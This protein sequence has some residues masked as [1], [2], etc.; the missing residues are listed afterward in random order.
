MVQ[1]SILSESDLGHV[2]FIEVLKDMQVPTSWGRQC[3]S[4]TYHP[5]PQLRQFF[6]DNSVPWLVDRIESIGFLEACNV[7][8]GEIGVNVDVLLKWIGQMSRQN[9]SAG[10]LLQTF[11]TKYEKLASITRTPDAVRQ[12]REAFQDPHNSFYFCTSN[13]RQWFSHEEVRWDGPTMIF[14]NLLG[15]LAQSYGEGMR[16]FFVDVLKVQTSPLA[17]DYIRALSCLKDKWDHHSFEDDLLPLY[18]RIS[19]MIDADEFAAVSNFNDLREERLF[20]TDG[21]KWCK[22]NE[23]IVD[24]DKS[25]LR[26]QLQANM[27]HKRLHFLASGKVKHV[28]SIERLLRFSN[29]SFLSEIVHVRITE[30]PLERVWS[31]QWTDHLHKLS[32]AVARLMQA[33]KCVRF[34]KCTW[35]RSYGVSPQRPPEK[36]SSLSMTM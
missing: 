20:L 22:A 21:G 12:V 3:F 23:L 24:D 16:R 8:F 18:Q 33:S 27:R 15:F 35:N 14:G 4:E 7:S 2:P 28:Q 9:P 26:K 13:G 5:D 36:M 34:P 31:E 19:K 25:D 32:M 6:D 11:R 10:D 30:Q 17:N 29:A 1:L